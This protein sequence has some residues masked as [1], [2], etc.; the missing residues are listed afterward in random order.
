M[1]DAMNAL[2]V[3]PMPVVSFLEEF[4]PTVA[5]TPKVPSKV[6]MD[7]FS[8][9]PQTKIEKEMYQPF[10]D[11]IQEH[12]LIP[13]YKIVNTADFPD[14][15]MRNGRKIRH[16]PSM[17]QK[18]LDTSKK[19]IQFGELELHFEL[20]PNDAS[21]P[22]NDPEP[23]V[24]R[25]NHQFLRPRT[26][27]GYECCSQLIHYAT[28]WCSRQ[29]RRFAFIIFIGDPYVRFIRW[30]RAGAVVSEKFDY[31]EDSRP[32]IEFLW[33]FTHADDAGRGN[34]PTVHRPTAK[35]TKDARDHLSE[36][37]PEVTRPVVV[38]D[39]PGEDGN[40]RQF[41]GWGSMSHPGSL[42]GRCTRAYP[43]YEP[44]TGKRYFLKDT[45]R[46]YDLAQ[47]ADILR[48][49]QAA[50]VE[51]IPPFVCGG[52][53]FGDYTM[54]DLFVPLEDEEEIGGEK[55][56]E[57]RVPATIVRLPKKD[58]SWRC[59]SDWKHITQR[60]HH[61]FVVDFIGKH[62]DRA[63][64][65]KA[66]M[67]A[68][69]DAFTAHRQAYE[70]CTIIHRDISARN[71]LVDDEGRGI[72]NDWDLVKHES[73]LKRGRRHERTGTW[74]FMSCLLLT[75]HH[76]IHTIQDDMES[77]VHIVLYH[78]LRYYPHNKPLSTL[79]LIRTIFNDQTADDDG[80]RVGGDNKKAMFRARTHIDVDFQFNSLPLR[81][82]M[83]WALA[84]ATQWINHVDPLVV[85]DEESLRALMEG[86]PSQ[87]QPQTQLR[88]ASSSLHIYLW[89]H[90]SMAT[91]FRNCLI[92]ETWPEKDSP[93][94]VFL[95]GT[96][97]KDLNKRESEDF[98][99]DRLPKRT[100]TSSLHQGSQA[101]S[102]RSMSTRSYTR[103]S[104][105]G[106]SGQ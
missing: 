60:F 16:D 51:H 81:A 6:A 86:P 34:D 14:H 105:V 89:N 13:G 69:S 91:A 98:D 40:L 76:T 56:D 106:G 66:M 27:K 58:G 82:W 88:I 92:L 24:D 32:L 23:G 59:G 85:D 7:H 53:L 80:S 15:H 68:V 101:V 25:L 2:F 99:E 50:G 4:L 35:Q 3:G 64:N 87:Q 94:D 33:R 44:A 71:I 29:H 46:A 72:L 30:D 90:T 83:G 37:D 19:R 93:I 9:M 18:S 36:W 8:K 96:T 1:N 97:L 28:K 20:K 49:L 57:C 70:R 74:E 39:V 38:F 65:S 75:G 100:K 48:E 84:A 104:N 61:R 73:E 63:K 102:S 5:G 79:R 95:S 62:L 31:R 78:G 10:I 42:T 55:C 41:I 47:E 52:D 22:F 103:R 45:W 54:A 26:I 77:F 21:D 43:V 11:L 12:G 17:Y 67:Q